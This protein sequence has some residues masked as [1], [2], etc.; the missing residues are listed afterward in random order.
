MLVSV[1][2]DELNLRGIP[3]FK[4]WNSLE[5][6]LY[7]GMNMDF[8]VKG[9]HK[10]KW[11][12]PYTVKKYGLDKSLKL[13]EDYIRNTPELYDNIDELEGKELGCWCESGKCH[14]DILIKLLKEKSDSEYKSND[15]LDRESK[16]H[17]TIKNVHKTLDKYGVAIIPN[18]IDKLEC[19]SIVSGMWDYYEHISSSWEIPLNRQDKNTWKLLY[20]LWPKHSMLQQHFNVGHSQVVWDVRQNEKVVKVFSDIWKTPMKDMLVSFD[21]FSFSVPHE[22]TNRGWYRKRTWYHSDQS[23]TRNDFE[24]IQGWITGLDVNEG[25]AT[26]T[27]Y[28]G[29][30]KY[31]KEFADEFKVTDRRDWYKLDKDEEE[32]YLNKGCTIQNIKCKKGSLVLWDSRTIHCG[33]E[34]DRY[35]KEPNFR[36]I[37]YVCYKPRRYATEAQLRKKRKAFNEMRT[38]SH[39]P[40]KGKL[41]PKLPQTYGKKLPDITKISPPVVS[42]LGKRLAGF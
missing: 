12:N 5:N 9:A 29:S 6:T 39:Y 20:E 4:E 40:C 23:F 8:F 33:K 2:K 1:K 11:Y 35:R 21:G 28:E 7:I 38:T 25:D 13:Y 10:S 34:A 30:H 26:L 37:V 31:H 17:T 15:N 42:E 24:C 41:F 22:V 3:N 32:F 19:E 14:G 18:V 27:F 16:Y 36:A